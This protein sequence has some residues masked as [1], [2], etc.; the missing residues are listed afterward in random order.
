M[1]LYHSDFLGAAAQ[2]LAALPL[3]RVLSRAQPPLETFG[4]SV[5]SKPTLQIHTLFSF[6]SSDHSN[7]SGHSL[8]I[9]KKLI[10]DILGYN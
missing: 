3:K 1:N 2:K 7:L 9:V 10:Y 6:Q 5:S 4:F 8:V